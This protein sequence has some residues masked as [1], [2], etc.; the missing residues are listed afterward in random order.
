[1]TEHAG[2]P[3]ILS[4]GHDRAIRS[5]RLD[6]EPG[7][8]DHPDA[9]TNSI[10]ALAV[11]EHGGRPLILSADADAVILAHRLDASG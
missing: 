9:H 7:P 4:A 11:V 5:W 1:M 8:L 2:R 3:L 10:L 6:G